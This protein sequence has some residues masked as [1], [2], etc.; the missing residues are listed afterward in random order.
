MTKAVF[1]F[2]KDVEGLVYGPRQ[3]AVLVEH[4]DL[5][6]IR[7]DRKN[8]REHKDLL[9]EVEV[10]LSSWGGPLIDE[11]FL[12]A[13]PNLKT[14]FYGAGS[15]K[16]IMT[17]AAWKR[18]IRITSAYAANAVPVAEFTLSQILFCLKHGWRMIREVRDPVSWKGDKVVPGVF[19]TTVGVV[20][21]GMTGRKVCELLQPF[22][23]NVIAFDPYVAAEDFV[24]LGI[25][26][27]SLE[28]V[29]AESDVVALH[30]PWLPETEGMITGRLLESMKSGASFINVARGALIR[31]NEL[32]DVMRRRTDLTAVLDVVVLE[33]PAPD[34]PLFDLSNVVVTPHLAGSMHHECRRMGEYMVEELKRA[35][36]GEPMRWEI[37]R[38]KATRLA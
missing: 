25:K 21:L 1:F 9:Q 11:E 28:Q 22:D 36:S 18:G 35:L 24:A 31:E 32:I 5:A 16:G 10:I 8:W 12:A 30:A 20:S 23:V 7:L 4:V 14:V 3:K 34:S 6:G 15:I 2:N 17:E 27:A 26:S 29:F 19:R 38:E 33:P 13:A 37:T